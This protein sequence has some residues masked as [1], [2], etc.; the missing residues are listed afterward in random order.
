MVKNAE[1]GEVVQIP[2]RGKEEAFAQFARPVGNP[3][4]SRF[5]RAGC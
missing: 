1:R 3:G 5:R 2:G 4:V